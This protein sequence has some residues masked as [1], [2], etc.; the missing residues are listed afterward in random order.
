MIFIV[1]IPIIIHIVEIRIIQAYENMG[2]IDNIYYI[3]F[4]L[5]F[6]LVLIINKYVLF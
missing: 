1:Y 2:K 3:I 5:V 6:K 4:S